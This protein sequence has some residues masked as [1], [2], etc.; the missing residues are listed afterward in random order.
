MLYL[1]L[2]ILIYI[3]IFVL[4]LKLL[5]KVWKTILIFIL[6]LIL[7][8]II[9]GV[10]VFNDV[11]NI[12]E[13]F[14]GS[15]NLILIENEG[16]IITGLEIN[17]EEGQPKILKQPTINQISNYYEKRK[18]KN[19]LQPNYYKFIII[20]Y[21]KVIEPLIPNTVKIHEGYSIT[22]QELKSITLS[23]EPY[24]GILSL[25]EEYAE[26]IGNSQI[27][28]D[29]A[30]EGAREAIESQTNTDLE[31]KS[32][33]KMMV[34][35]LSL[36]DITQQSPET[37]VPFLFDNYKKGNI[38]I[39]KETIT[40]KIVKLLPTSLLKQIIVSQMPS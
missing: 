10:L 29:I 15:T 28:A 16:E 13:N 37:I 3:G 36:K 33:I 22:K 18:Y 8:T 12:M 5:K 11:T 34:I 24:E 31:D 1:L 40:L 32:N 20:S 6:I 9:F 26:G 30:V 14:P 38:K 25:L 21:S 7:S 19:I 17:T 35:M 39:Y 2:I 27:P 4:L 23:E